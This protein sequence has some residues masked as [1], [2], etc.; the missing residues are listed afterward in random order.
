MP[1]G[2]VAP[3]LAGWVFDRTGDYSTV[4]A[5]YGAIAATGTL[6]VLLIRR[7]LWREFQAARAAGAA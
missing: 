3:V 2:L 7:P 1:A 4:L 5:I 6:W